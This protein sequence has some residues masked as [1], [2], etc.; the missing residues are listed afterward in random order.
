MKISKGKV[1]NTNDPK[2]LGRI[3]VAIEGLYDNIDEEFI[4]FALPI[5]NTNR[6]YDLPPKDS[7]IFVLYEDKYSPYWFTITSG[8]A[9]NID[10]ENYN[11]GAILFHKKLEDY[12]SKGE[13]KIQF[14]ESN[15]FQINYT[16]GDANNELN[17]R[18]DNSISLTNNNSK[19]KIHI[20]NESI[21]LGSETKSNESAVL[22]EQNE[23]VLNKI[24]NARNKITEDIISGLSEIQISAGSSPYTSN[25]VA[26]ITKLINKLTIDENNLKTDI[27]NFIPKT[28]SNIVSLD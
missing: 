7:Y 27:E 1:V 28:K 13:I 26:P 22:G 23:E 8:S 25:L 6:T 10:D 18:S 2:K 5:G 15:G 12:N 3:K 19:K 4:P 20:S 14:S 9:I 21:S 24:N 17:L 16:Y 11:S